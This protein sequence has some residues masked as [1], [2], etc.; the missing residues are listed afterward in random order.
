M[1]SLSHPHRFDFQK[2]LHLLM[3]LIP[4]GVLGNLIFMF[5]TTDRQ[6]IRSVIQFSPL[7][8]LLAILMT[9]VPW[10]TNA[11]RLLIWTRFLGHRI[12]YRAL[13][14]ITI[15]TELGASVTPSAVGGAPFKMGMLMQ[16]GVTTGSAASLTT[17]GSVED[18]LFFLVAVPLALT[19]STSWDLPIFRTLWAQIHHPY[20][21]GMIVLIGFIALISLFFRATRRQIRT[22]LVNSP[23]SQRLIQRVLNFWADFKH[24]YK[25]IGQ[26][27]KLWFLLSML[28]TGF[29]WTCRY[30]V[31]SALVASLG[32]P[33]D[34]LQFFA[35]QWVVFSLGTLIPTP[36]ATGGIEA[37]FYLIY[38]AI[39]PNHIISLAMAG[40]RFLT[41]Y[42]LLV[43]DIVLYF[44][45]SL[46]HFE[47]THITLD[48]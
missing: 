16:R 17:L 19:F 10:F 35:L 12:R 40:W 2:S 23:L 4:V 41:F 38:R 43:I 1:P 37:A 14:K 22:W 15:A 32:F 26:T 36:G 28:V 5:Y 42:F 44:L 27:G 34:V 29:Q 30:S 24:V 31:I 33:V 47:D 11:L 18:G 9:M 7:F 21:A 25:L 3:I 13:F 39:L 6:I 20:L 8:F 48:N 45:L 46:P